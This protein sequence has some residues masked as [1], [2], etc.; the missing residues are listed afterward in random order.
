MLI[1]TFSIYIA[2]HIFKNGLTYI[3]SFNGPRIDLKVAAGNR[4]LT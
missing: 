4:Y 1:A 2:L 3:N